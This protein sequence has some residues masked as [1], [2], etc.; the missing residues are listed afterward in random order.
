MAREIL[1]TLQLLFDLIMTGVADV[2]QV[3]T[4]INTHNKTRMEIYGAGLKRMAIIA[5]LLPIPLLIVSVITRIYWLTAWV[6]IFW[7]ITS[8]LLLLLITPIGL[9][10]EV[11]SG[12]VKGSGTRYINFVLG[13]LLSELCITIFLV[14]VPI[15]NNYAVL[16]ILIIL[17][18]IL[19]IIGAIG[20]NNSIF[21]KRLITTLAT[22]LFIVLILS[23]FFPNLSR[24]T[25]IK[26]G[27]IDPEI[28][29][30]LTCMEEENRNKPECQ[31]YKPVT[32]TPTLIIPTEEE[33][34]YTAPPDKWS[35]QI[36]IPENYWYRITDPENKIII[37]SWSGRIYAPTEKVWEGDKIIDAH[38][39][40]K[41]VTRKEE[42]I[43]VIFRPK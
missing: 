2:T 6:G 36:S 21:T 3:L 24:Y 31:N 32:P 1:R 8:V 23:L 13:I 16:P 17:A 41:S 43:K 34:F 37:K 26:A 7:A 5:I 12:G 11:V 22:L 35:E 28:T 38:Y 29:K 39:W 25:A 42:I 19:G 33:R 27:K 30:L 15:K 14:I 10:I 20:A 4:L 40:I 18:A 9:L